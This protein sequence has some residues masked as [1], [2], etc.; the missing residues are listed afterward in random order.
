LSEAATGLEHDVRTTLAN[1]WRLTLSLVATWSVAV[2]IRLLL[3]RYLG[4]ELFGTYIFAESLALTGIGLLS[5]GIDAYIQKEIPVRPAHASDFFGGVLVLR[6]LTAILVIAAIVGVLQATGRSPLTL[7]VTAIFGAGLWLRL[8]NN[9]LAA[10]LQANTTIDGLA[11]AN[12]LSKLTWGAMVG[13]GIILGA[14]LT[15]LAAAL[16]VGEA[17][18]TVLLARIVSKELS[19][20]VRVDM[21]TT[22]SVIRANLPLYLNGLV[23]AVNARLGVA[24][25]GFLVPDERV[26]GWYG[27]AVNLD[28]IT[29]ML[30]PLVFPLVMP[31]LSRS[32]ARS[33]DEF[34][35]VFRL[36]L[37]LMLAL[38]M[39]ASL[40]IALGADLWVG[41][42]FG[43][44]FAPG[45]LALRALASQVAITYVAMTA[46][47]AL[48]ILGRSWVLARSSLTGLLLSPTTAVLLIPFCQRL[49]GS[50]GAGLGAALSSVGAELVVT[51]MVFKGLG[52]GAL[53]TETR[54]AFSRTFLVCG[55]VVAAHLAM[56]PLGHARLLVGAVLYV[57]LAA[58]LGA[59]PV[60]RVGAWIRTLRRLQRGGT[61]QGS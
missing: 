52:P 49:W 26:I 10:L 32:L 38:A 31:L 55:L 2:V 42:A 8:I 29:L 59:V 30:V 39:P 48:I 45:A 7:V 19:L 15:V 50:P 18:R 5:F 24:V 60:R 11:V 21:P 28:A 22:L 27:G 1:A 33:E 34:W 43:K 12:P 17:L 4:P 23:V 13:I 16:G 25:L 36:T 20:T 35:A 46:S 54:R 40:F 61:I 44:E 3:P 41:L 53:D 37:K 47:A 56:A 57:G 51:A 9:T 6:T 14:P 58:L